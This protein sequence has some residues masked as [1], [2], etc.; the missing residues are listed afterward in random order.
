MQTLLDG[1]CEEQ[2]GLKVHSVFKVQ[3]SLVE[4]R[5]ENFWHDLRR[6][7]G[8]TIVR[9]PVLTDDFAPEDRAKGTS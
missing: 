4:H 8:G 2:K 3:N 6:K 1:S 7:F 5:F 9:H